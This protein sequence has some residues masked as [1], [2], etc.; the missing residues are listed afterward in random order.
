MKI[1]KFI[2]FLLYPVCLAIEKYLEIR[3]GKIGAIKRLGE[4]KTKL[5]RGREGI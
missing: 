4:W 1:I 5:M 2:C 3:Y